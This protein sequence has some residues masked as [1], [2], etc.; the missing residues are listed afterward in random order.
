MQELNENEVKIHQHFAGTLFNQTWE[1]IEKVDRSEDENE[2]MLL[3]AYASYYHWTVVGKPIHFV[4]GEWMVAKINVLL[5]RKEAALHHSKRCLTMTLQHE[6]KDFDLAYAYEMFARAN[7][8]SGNYS[9]AQEYYQL[10]THAIDGIAKEEDKKQFLS[11]LTA[12]PW[13]GLHNQ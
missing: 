1:F 2:Q 11:D 13:F 3:R 8:L 4:R 10:S 5:E 9:T 7:A 12:E 6:I